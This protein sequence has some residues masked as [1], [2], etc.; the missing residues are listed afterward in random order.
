[1]RFLPR[2]W[3]EPFQHIAIGE[4]IPPRAK[5]TAHGG[6][7]VSLNQFPIQGQ[8]FPYACESQWI[9][10]RAE[11]VSQP[12]LATERVALVPADGHL[13]LCREHQ[14]GRCQTHPD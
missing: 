5:L 14:A 13:R 2:E 6:R 3:P 9:D 12:G 1:M 10:E 11:P 4:Q 7:F 8:W